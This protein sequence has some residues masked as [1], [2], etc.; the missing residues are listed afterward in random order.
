MQRDP[1]M[2]KD[3]DDDISQL[4]ELMKSMDKLEAYACVSNAYRE[5]NS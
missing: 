2:V 1:N 4:I 3:A 5:N